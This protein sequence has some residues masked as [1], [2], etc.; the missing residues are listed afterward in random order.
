MVLAQASAGA[1]RLE[2]LVRVAAGWGWA[3]AEREQPEDR[4][5]R[6][7][8]TARMILVAGPSL[9]RWRIWVIAAMCV[10][11]LRRPV[12]ARRLPEV[13]QSPGETLDRR[14][15]PKAAKRSRV[16]DRGTPATS[17]ITA[18]AAV[19]LP[20]EHRSAFPTCA[21]QRAFRHSNRLLHK[22]Q[23]TA[24]WTANTQRPAG[25]HRDAGAPDRQVEAGDAAGRR[26][27]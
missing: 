16:T 7:W 9:C 4:G 20:L 14:V 8:S 1:R 15:P 25:T 27:A 23:R 11:R 6:R 24:K 2:S 10:G 3:T 5:F 13:V 18:A 12:L 22:E 26:V 19:F 17:P 21:A